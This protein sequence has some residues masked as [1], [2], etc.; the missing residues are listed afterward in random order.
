MSFNS[1]LLTSID[2]E[3]AIKVCSTPQQ[4]VDILPVLVEIKIEHITSKFIPFV[5]LNHLSYDSNSKK[6][7]LFSM[8]SIFR[9]TH[10]AKN[11]ENIWQVQLSEPKENDSSPGAFIAILE[12]QTSKA[13]GWDKLG[14]MMVSMTELKRAE[15][16]YKV[17]LE[18]IDAS[19]KKRNY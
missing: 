10:M 6:D 1:F 8:T 17:L 11:Q 14:Q 4:N 13:K 15:E 12:I 18:S 16:L 9:I 3:S 19:D 5:L 2:R 7:I